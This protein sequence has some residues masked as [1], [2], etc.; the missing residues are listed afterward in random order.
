MEKK[1]Y[2]GIDLGGTFVKGGV[3]DENGVILTQDK[4][5]TEREKGGDKVVEN[6]AYLTK[7]VIADAGLELSQ[8]QGLGMGVPGMIDSKNGVVIYSNNLQW[9]DFAIGEE[10]SSQTGLSVKIAND[11]NVAAL[12][13][14][15][16]GAA[17][18]YDNAIMLTLG[19]GV[20]S[21]IV[22]DGKLVEGNKSAG[23]ELGHAVIVLNGEQCTCG[24]KGCLEAYASA[25]A[26]IRDTKRAMKAHKD[27]CLISCSF[28]ADLRRK[29]CI[30]RFEI[31]ERA[32]PC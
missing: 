23:A 16:F 9:K 8:V 6:I 4:V 25:T 28:L 3:V 12:G 22:I 31:D 11:A 1:Y 29:L 5:P 21:G 18:A 17:K 7:K 32:F 14:V 15:K 19:T 20:G 27:Y 10:V 2:V 24:R 26:L 30:F 13:E